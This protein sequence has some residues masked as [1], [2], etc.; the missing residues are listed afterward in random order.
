MRLQHQLL[1]KPDEVEQD[2]LG[3]QNEYKD[4]TA[5]DWWIDATE[6]KDITV[7]GLL[8][9]RYFKNLTWHYDQN[10]QLGLLEIVVTVL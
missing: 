1:Q 8:T 5:Q 6:C 10:C 3:Y 4:G 7:Y 9:A 2:L